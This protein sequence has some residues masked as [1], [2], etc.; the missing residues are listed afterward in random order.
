MAT[1][2]VFANG[3][4]ASPE[5]DPGKGIDTS[6]VQL[7]FSFRPGVVTVFGEL[8][9]KETATELVALLRE[10]RP[11]SKV[12]KGEEFS[13]SADSW[14]P[15]IL[16]L[17]SV[18]SELSVSIA[19][20]R[21]TFFPE[22]IIIEGL[23]DSPVSLSALRVRLQPLIRNRPIHDRVCLVPTEDLLHYLPD[24]D[25]STSP[26]G[27]LVTIPVANPTNLIDE[28]SIALAGL[29][30]DKWISYLQKTSFEEMA[31]LDATDGKSKKSPWR[32]LN[33]LSWKRNQP[34]SSTNS[35][36]KSPQTTRARPVEEKPEALF[37]AKFRKNSDK[38]VVDSE[39]A[40]REV[41]PIFASTDW[42]E[43]PIQLHAI[44]SKGARPA[45]EEYQM[46]R[47]LDRVKAALVEAGV[48]AERIIPS[49]RKNQETEDLP[50]VLI[51]A[52]AP[53]LEEAEPNAHESAGA[54]QPS[55]P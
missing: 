2:M 4:F 34:K 3:C 33:F 5:P 41:A 22:H 12:F 38:L 7:G 55:S 19:N 25:A 29:A 9:N 49:L 46:E 47:R 14:M 42:G 24:Q 13:Y 54:A 28:R 35:I 26:V 18:L 1:I 53:R 51:L 10:I 15:D 36:E 45:L 21:I 11:D 32:R 52:V 44:P 31:P 48:S 20:G 17:R 30:P 37:C 39:Q 6:T 43:T 16:E 27:P 23:T 8:P 40:L 50:E